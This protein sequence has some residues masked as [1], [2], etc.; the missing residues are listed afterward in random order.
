MRLLVISIDFPP[1]SG[2]IAR[3]TGRLVRELRS[4]GW[5]VEVVTDRHLE[6][7]EGSIP[8]LGRNGR[9][10]VR[11]AMKN[12]VKTLLRVGAGFDGVLAGDAGRSAMTAAFY[13]Y[14]TGTPYCQL[15]HGFDFLSWQQRPSERRWAGPLLR[16][17]RVG[18]CNSHPTRLRAERAKLASKLTV[19]HPG[20]DCRQF[21]PNEGSE[22]RTDGPARLLT[23][24]RLIRRKG[25]HLVLDALSDISIA[26][27]YRIIG[28]G[29]ERAVIQDEVDRRG[30]SSWVSLE[31]ALSDEELIEAYRWADLFILT[32][33]EIPETGHIEGFG[34]VYLEA[35][36]CGLPVLGSRSGGVE[37]AVASDVSG[38]L[39]PS[40]DP[41]AIRLELERLLS[42]PDPLVRGRRLSARDWALRFDWPVVGQRASELLL[43]T[44]SRCA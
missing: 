18:I 40:N 5:E 20:V 25:V 26:F 9:R 36:A 37:D 44:F 6:P 10:P 11:E 13:R 41:D 38:W 30:M 39:V 21:R 28:D 42:G 4:L 35:N 23:V 14:L 3:F 17:S 29:P 32:P 22:P 16:S 34:I 1:A 19:L 43:H 33:I 27:E 8:I 7:S 15:V 12:A 2:G 24:S 31:G